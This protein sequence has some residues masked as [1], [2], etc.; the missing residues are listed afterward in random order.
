LRNK[1]R[2]F[3]VPACHYF[4]LGEVL[5]TLSN[6]VKIS[7]V[8]PVYHASGCLRELYQ[9][10]VQ[11]LEGLGEDFEIVLVNDGSPDDSWDIILELAAGDS[12][13]KGVNLSRNFGQH[14]AI[15][16][17]LDHA[18]GD[19]IVVMDCDLQDQPEEIPQLYA[20]ALEGY[21]IVFARRTNRKDTLIKKACSRI[22]HRL[23]HF[24]SDIKIDPHVSNF[25]IASRHVVDAMLNL[26]ERNRAYSVF[27]Q[28][29]GFQTTY[30]DVEHGKRFSGKSSY[31]FTKSVRVAVEAITSQ[32]NKPLRLSIYIG[33]L[34]SI[35]SFVYATYRIVR[36][37]THGVDVDGWTSLMVAVVFIGGLIL[38][39]LGVMGLYLGKVFDESKH[40][41]LYV[42]QQLVNLQAISEPT[43]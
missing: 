30:I 18:A 33:F 11:V 35:V 5:V 40:R 17:G 38:A 8:S 14:C 4:I 42:T 7:I 27:L 19:W 10:L 15:T 13:V 12:R 6:R 3:V 24:L 36:Y 23:Y 32:S 43:D 22:F 1:T 39:N 34:M 29:L 31:G 41:P 28:W 25:S 26:R 9:R 2:T 21:Q 37:Y 16:A 20:K